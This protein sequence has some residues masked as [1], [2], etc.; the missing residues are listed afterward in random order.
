MC[1]LQETLK[2]LTNVLKMQFYKNIYLNT[3]LCVSGSFQLTFDFFK[4][5]DQHLESQLGVIASDIAENCAKRPQRSVM[6]CFQQMI[7]FHNSCHISRVVQ[8]VV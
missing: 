2:T 7:E 3:V 8:L 1:V 6:C 5:V 4:R